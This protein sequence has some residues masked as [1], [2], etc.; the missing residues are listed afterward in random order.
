MGRQVVVP[1][2]VP[3]M[4]V[5]ASTCGVGWRAGVTSP[6]HARTYLL[7]TLAI[8][9]ATRHR[10]SAI[11]IAQVWRSRGASKPAIV[12]Q[13]EKT[14]RESAAFV[15]TAGV[16]AYLESDFLNMRSIFSLVVSTAD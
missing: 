2:S 9:P 10:T 15:F 8:A 6:T 12:L 5:P 7:S 11:V 13:G 1:L 16:S 4:S 3:Q 14:P